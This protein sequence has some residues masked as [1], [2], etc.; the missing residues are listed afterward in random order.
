MRLC[1]FLAKT[2][3]VRSLRKIAVLEASAKQHSVHVLFKY[4]RPGI[5]Y[6]EGDGRGVAEWAKSLKQSNY[7]G[8]HLLASPHELSVHHH[9]T[10]TD[11]DTAM[12]PLAISQDRVAGWRMQRVETLSEFAQE[13]KKRGILLWWRQKMG[14]SNEMSTTEINDKA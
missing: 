14:F 5:F 9:D 8:Y 3:H 7:L 2:H 1:N 12:D 11:T 4:G 6:C 10:G 13:M